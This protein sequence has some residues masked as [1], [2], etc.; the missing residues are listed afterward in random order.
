MDAYVG[1]AVTVVVTIIVRMDPMTGTTVLPPAVGADAGAVASD[2]TAGVCIDTTGVGG[3]MTV[4]VCVTKP[5]GSDKGLTVVEPRG[6]PGRPTSE[7]DAGTEAKSDGLGIAGTMVVET[8][9]VDVSSMS[10]DIA[11]EEV[12]DSARAVPGSGKTGSLNGTVIVAS[13][14][15]R[16]V[17]VPP[18][19]TEAVARIASVTE[20]VGG[21]S[22]TGIGA[23]MV[24]L[25]SEELSGVSV[26]PVVADD[27]LIWD[28]GTGA[29]PVLNVDGSMSVHGPVVE[30]E[31]AGSRAAAVCADAIPLTGTNGEV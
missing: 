23:K 22:G 14:D 2:E 27:A 10:L 3:G 29:M 1:L 25:D 24:L 30:L 12:T 5:D 21:D 7:T 28:A 19:G 20:D 18:A 16:R 6:D 11:A 26:F 8:R 15:I 9:T 31:G 17:T 4:I 13:V